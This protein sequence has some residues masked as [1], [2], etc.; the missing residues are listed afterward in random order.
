MLVRDGFTRARGGHL[1]DLGKHVKCYIKFIDFVI[2]L[3]NCSYF[4]LL[5]HLLFFHLQIHSIV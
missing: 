4:A 2:F 5:I 3:D 1:F